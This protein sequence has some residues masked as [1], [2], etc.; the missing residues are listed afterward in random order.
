[1][2][3]RSAATAF[4]GTAFLLAGTV[5]ATGPATAADPAPTPDLT[6][7]YQQ[8]LSWGD[9]KGE[10]QKKGG[11]ALKGM[12]CT[13]LTVPV[14]YANTALGTL[15]L[16][17]GRYRATAPGD[18]GLGSLVFNFGG[19][20]ASGLTTLAE[21]KDSYKSLGKRYDLVTF[22]P[23]GVGRS[24]PVKCGKEADEELKEGDGA[25]QTPPDGSLDHGELV[26]G[27]KD[28]ATACAKHTGKLL[29]YVGTIN[30]S[31]DL[32][33][34]RQALGD[35]KLAY[36]GISY[37]TRLGAV[38]AAQ[39]P[40]RSGRLVLDAVD[41]LTEGA[42]ASALDQARGFQKA[43]DAFLAA[44]AKNGDKCPL[45][46]T[47]ADATRTVDRVVGRLTRTPAKEEDG[48]A[49][50]VEDLRGAM[51][52]ALYSAEAWPALA[53]G[54]AMIDQDDD[55]SLLAD[56]NRLMEDD[57]NGDEAL[58]AVNCA[59]DPDR[60]PVSDDE[61]AKIE[62]E[63]TEASPVFGRDMVGSALSCTGW[64]AGTDYIRKLEKITGP[65]VLLIGTK[66]DPAT[67]YRWTEETAKRLGRAVVLRYDGEGH[68]GY[69]A[70]PCIREKT[71]AY[72]LDG[73]L[74]AAGTACP[75]VDPGTPDPDGTE[76]PETVPGV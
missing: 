18:D 11:D 35:E 33:V 19:P 17:V 72:L 62:K 3:I 21:A 71:D 50:G 57:G 54:I 73:T 30:V 66:G 76:L 25:P 56:L 13:R 58:I 64:P 10:E 38:Y 34:L 44:C 46:S 29:P 5:T 68:G 24:A 9:C 67:P 75:A 32:D 61:L 22:D 27:L 7:F 37:G 65:E 53:E 69:S 14:D 26:K 23:R 31:R 45:G 55:P 41:T 43:F 28:I 70:S 52:T 42:R 1:M 36:L 40:D 47:A 2:H 8:K 51:T 16:A 74:P 63:F 60:T 48:T 59:D 49:F 15:D 12:E 20:G 6:R 4:A 39:F